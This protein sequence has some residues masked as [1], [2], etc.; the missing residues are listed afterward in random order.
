MKVPL[1][2]HF[3]CLPNLLEFASILD[4]LISLSIALKIRKNV[5]EEKI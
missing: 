5:D 3:F 1:M 2:G 4:V